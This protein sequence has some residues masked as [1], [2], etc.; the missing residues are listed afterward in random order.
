MNVLEKLVHVEVAVSELSMRLHRC[1]S[2]SGFEQVKQATLLAQVVDA[3]YKLI[4]T[5]VTSVD[6][7]HDECGNVLKVATKS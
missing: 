1:V 3:D 2:T 4:Q 5:I 7:I 6:F